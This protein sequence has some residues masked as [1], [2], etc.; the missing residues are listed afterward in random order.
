MNSIENYN[1]DLA[2]FSDMELMLEFAKEMNF[3]EKILSNR[4]F[5]DKC[6]NRCLKSPPIMARSFTQIFFKYKMA[7]I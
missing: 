1:V 2:Y 3:D 5:G 7:T 4:S 6:L